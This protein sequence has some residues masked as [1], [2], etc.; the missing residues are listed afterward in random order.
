MNLVEVLLTSGKDDLSTADG[1]TRSMDLALGRSLADCVV[2]VRP[3]NDAQT[4][5]KEAEGLFAATTSKSKFDTYQIDRRARSKELTLFH[6]H[7]YVR[8]IRKK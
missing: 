6:W 3:G 1:E 4:W 7:T 2:R 5:E 8:H